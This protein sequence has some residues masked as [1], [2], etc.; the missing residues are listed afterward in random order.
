VEIASL[1]TGD[2]FG[3]MAML[4]NKPR[5]A[6]VACLTP[7]HLFT[8][9]RYAFASLLRQADTQ[10]ISFSIISA[11]VKRVRAVSEKYFAEE[12]AQRTLQAEMEAERHRALAQM[13]A[14]VAHELNTPLGVV[15]T[16]A[17]M[18]VK[19]VRSE[20]LTAALS[21]NQAARTILADMREAAQLAGRNIS[22]AHTLV[23]NFKK[24][25]A[26]QLMATRE[27]VDL[28]ACVQEML[29]LFSINVRRA[30]LHIRI[31]HQLPQDQ[32][33]WTGYPG[34]LTQVLTNL[35]FNIERYAYP[36]QQ[37]GL[38]D[39]GLQA[40]PEGKPPHFVLMV[41]DYGCGIAPDHLPQIFT[42]FF[43]TG[44]SRGG[45]GLG[46]AIVH[47]IVTEALQGTITV[48]SARDQ[49]TTF[50]VIFPQ[51]IHRID[52]P[53]IQQTYS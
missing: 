53:P 47:N 35:L 11:L 51:T 31:N 52:L 6:T 12:L 49:G 26:N 28:P 17:D 13:V 24:I 39:I 8:L 5:S 40:E 2:F 42:P 30:N 36:D 19:R 20:T 45:T 3:E 46:L 29:D 38:I 43:T 10:A 7:C 9:D 44:R 27:T 33:A 25:S 18:I 21:D 4:D 48:E 15:N 23:E 16:A 34:Y 50:T 37:G 41:Q 22:R 32:T 14:G 1:Q